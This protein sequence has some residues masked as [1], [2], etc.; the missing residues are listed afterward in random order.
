[1]RQGIGGEEGG[2]ERKERSGL[3]EAPPGP[4]YY[5]CLPVATV[6]GH[7]NWPPGEVVS[8]ACLPATHRLPSACSSSS[9]LAHPRN[10]GQ[11]NLHPLCPPHSCH[12]VPSCGHSVLQRQGKD[13]ARSSWVDLR[14]LGESQDGG[15]RVT[16]F[17][18]HDLSP[19][20]LLDFPGGWRPSSSCGSEKG[21][22]A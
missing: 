10:R 13:G 6:P 7:P 15:S 8:W 5:L 12:R 22:E 21:R 17:P 14:D 3:R 16:S 19:F 11:P 18:L 20:L 1:M 9:L 2:I 4:W